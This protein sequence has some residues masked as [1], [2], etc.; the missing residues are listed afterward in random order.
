MSWGSFLKSAG[1]KVAQESGK[2]I[3]EKITKKVN[4]NLR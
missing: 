2:K 3:A 1:S 4:R